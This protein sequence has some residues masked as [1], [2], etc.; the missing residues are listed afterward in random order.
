M[1]LQYE[2]IGR[3]GLAL[4]FALVCLMGVASGKAQNTDAQREKPPSTRL[5]TMEEG[6]SIA[7]AAQ[8]Q[9][10]P[11]HGTQD[12][13]HLIHE[14]Y[15]SAGF[16]YPYASSFELFAGNENFARV[17][18]PHAGDLIVWPGHVGIVVDPLQHSFSSLVST[19]FDVQDYE[20]A[21]WKSRGR[22]RFYRYKVQ[23]GG[24]LTAAKNPA[25]RQASNANRP[26]GD[27]TLI[28]ERSGEGNST[29]G[30]PTKA[31]SERTM[32]IYGPMAP[33]EA[34]EASGPFE[35]PTSTIVAAGGRPPTREEVAEG[36]SE[37]SD[38]AG[39]LL[40]KDDPLKTRSPVLIVEQ[41]SVVRVEIKRDHGWARLQVE[42]KVS[43]DGGTIHQKPR[44]ENVRWELRR[45]PAGWEVVMPQDRTYVPHD[46]AVKDLAAQL[47][48]L[49]QS[50]GATAHGATAVQQESHIANLLSALLVQ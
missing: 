31:S 26:P 48:G 35:I 43:I 12:C 18:Y 38:A 45:V 29:L 20:G 40:R 5:L 25:S 3:Q 49:T 28:E 24:V 8:G 23:N 30:R 37:L 33:E 22:P 27:G 21:Y 2:A 14:I 36:I 4:A 34:T 19:G 11:T 9:E 10:Q 42:S 50:E 44:R 1:K 39:N 46:V 15:G 17:R 16:E 13:S 7:D 6:R 41:F 32:L 47:A